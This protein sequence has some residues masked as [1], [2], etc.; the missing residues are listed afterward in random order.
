M[1]G[2]RKAI[3]RWRYS[4]NG[5]AIGSTE[6]ANMEGE[7]FGEHR[8]LEIAR[9]HRHLSTPFL[10]EKIVEA[11]RRFSQLEQADDITLVVARCCA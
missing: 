3:C 2:P 6:A 5:I 1:P 4:H 7:E 11:A 8:L 10:L 9:A